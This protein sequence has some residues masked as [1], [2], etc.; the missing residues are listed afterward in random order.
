MSKY[1]VKLGIGLN[2]ADLKSVKQTINNIVNKQHDIDININY[3]LKNVNKLV[4]AGREIENI[5]AQLKE[6]NS[7][8]SVGKGKPLV[9]VDSKSL[10]ADL[11]RISDKT[12]DLNKKIVNL[13]NAFGKVDSNKGVQSL[14]TT[15][16]K[17]KIAIEGVSKEFA[18][19]NQNLSALSSKNFSMNFDFGF[20]NSKNKPTEQLD[21]ELN[22]LKKQVDEYEKYIN[23]VFSKFNT[24]GTDGVSML[25]G[26]AGIKQ[27]V[28]TDVLGKMQSK[29]LS[30]QV[31]AYKEY[32]RLIREASE[33][34]GVPL[35]IA[36][37]K[38]STAGVTSSLD[39][40]ENEA[41]ETEKKLRELFSGNIDGS[42]LHETLDKISI[43]LN[44]IQ[45][46]L[47]SLSEGVSIDKITQSFKEMD[48]VLDTLT[49]NL[50][51]IQGVLGSS[52]AGLSNSSVS[53]I[54]QGLKDDIDIL[55][56]FKASLK[57]MGMGDE[58]ISAIANKIKSLGVNVQTLNQSMSSTKGR[59]VLNV[60][61]SG[62]DK[63]GNAITLTKQYD[64]ATTELIKN[65]D[66]VSTV[67]QKAGA[68][69]NKFVQQQKQ[70]VANLTNTI[71]Q[72]HSASID[73]SAS[74]P[75]KDQSH[76]NALKSKYHEIEI[77]IEEM[78]RA[79]NE[80]FTD[81]QIKV[82]EL[83]SEYK[84]MK[85][86]FRNAE[87]VSS[88]LKGTDLKS[89]IDIARNSLEKFKAEAKG[90][91]QITQTI[92]NLDKAIE[93]VGDKSSLDAF[94]DQ[95]K[96]AKSELARVKAEASSINKKNTLDLDRQNALLRLDNL[97]E[98]NSAAAKKFGGR[99]EELRRRIESCDDSAAFKNIKKDIANL[100][101]EIK[102]SNL[103]TQTFTGR[104]KKEFDKY[105]GYFSVA[106]VF[107]YVS[108]GMRDMF[109]QVVAIDSA[110][111][112][113]KK[114]TDETSYTYDKF[115][116]NAGKRAQELGTTIDGLVSS[117]ADFARLGYDFKDAQG[118]AEVANIYAVVGDDID[119][120]ETATQS[121]ISTLTAFKDEAG[122]LSNT[123]FALSI[124]DKM[125]EVSNNFAIS[126]GG[127]GEALQ[128]SASSMMAANNSLDETIAL[129][130]A[131]NT[132]VSLCHAA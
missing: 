97:F 84:I 18:I 63:F 1:E 4:E 86:E 125:N 11:K 121:L 105:K 6:L 115:L 122:D 98:E 106:S 123:D 32:V 50:K 88:K 96:V 35:S 110:M 117:T 56:R 30:R 7:S 40:I 54:A 68:A 2:D 3:N 37:G 38:L 89:G 72:L 78:G 118:L 5:K 36:D 127:I 58:Q 60:D 25:F 10:H 21:K 85:A 62:I 109:N 34:A 9:T 20:N 65:V 23:K 126:S 113:L 103:Q 27:N 15:V 100:N 49:A 104:L 87:N 12:S 64:A 24:K 61:I 45:K 95:L 82:K 17:I 93:G 67:Q 102:K 128:R 14:L 31:S 33:L 77:A 74:R 80:T 94:N 57:N 79:T 66:K 129:I 39:K 48:V 71:K 22:L 59:K 13:Q 130:T 124:V 111:T 52:A 108:M 75:I 119:S 70:A 92:K 114:V 90:F 16:N 91:P 53:N 112:E 55:E 19:L 132:V 8:A 42:R 44:N 41:N 81:A 73:Q 69:T 120:V 51:Q 46:S 76:L 26:R 116:T 101:L 47:S 99:V 28:F 43:D 83:I 131:A 29:D 107:M